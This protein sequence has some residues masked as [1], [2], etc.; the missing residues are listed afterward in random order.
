M[1]ERYCNVSSEKP[2][3]SMGDHSLSNAVDYPQAYIE[4]EVDDGDDPNSN[5]VVVVVFPLTRPIHLFF[6]Q[7]PNGTSFSKPSLFYFL[8]LSL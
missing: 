8:S 1:L 2:T 3:I 6:N 5:H 4:E 7:R